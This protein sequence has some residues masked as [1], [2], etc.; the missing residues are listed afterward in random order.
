MKNSKTEYKCKQMN[1]NE[2][3]NH[4]EDKKEETNQV[5]FKHR[6]L[7]IY[8]QA[9]NKT[10]NKYGTLVNGFDFTMVCISSSKVTFCIVCDG[11]NK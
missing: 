3:N 9:K 4:T 5:S 11:T 10:V 6:V 8:L 2:E 1:L 7:T